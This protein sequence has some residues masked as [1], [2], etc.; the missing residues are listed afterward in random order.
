MKQISYS[1]SLDQLIECLVEDI[2]DI[3]DG[4]YRLSFLLET[5]PSI[6]DKLN[7]QQREGFYPGLITRIVGLELI[8]VDDMGPLTVQVLNGM[9]VVDKI[10]ETPNG[11]DP[12]NSGFIE[13]SDGFGENSDSSGESPSS[14]GGINP[15]PRA[16]PK[17]SGLLR[18]SF[19]RN[20]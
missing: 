4:F 17:R 5:V 2:V 14:G 18:P 11:F 6:I 13:S 12:N 8:R 10:S 1:F 20:S 16:I 7:P 3:E 15:Y 19:G 9:I